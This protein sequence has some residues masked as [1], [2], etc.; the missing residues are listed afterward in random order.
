MNDDQLSLFS[1]DQ[2]LTS[3][4]ESFDDLPDE[5]LGVDLNDAPE[6]TIAEPELLTIQLFKQAICEAEGNEGDRLLVDFTELVLPKLMAKLA[7]AAELAEL[8]EVV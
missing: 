1:K 2:P 7:G 6:Q 8:A 5:A 3:F 4:G